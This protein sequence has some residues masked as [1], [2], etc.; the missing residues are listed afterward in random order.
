VLSLAQ[1][2]RLEVDGFSG[3][4]LQPAYDALLD[5]WREAQDRET[6]LRLLFLAWY[7]MAE[8]SFLTGLINPDES[9]HVA[10]ERDARLVAT[11]V[12]H[13]LEGTLDV[14]P[15][16]LLTTIHLIRVCP[17]AFDMTERE[18]EELIRR[19]KGA[20]QNL[21]VTALRAESF[22]GRGAYGEYFSE[23][24]PRIWPQ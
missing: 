24:A 7:A 20:A 22:A 10:E 12:L 5:R 4:N 11:E 1:I 18:S 8:P 23:I 19:Y 16:F 21:G 3:S 14:D 6:G 2:N 15:E 17:W 13:T 9:P